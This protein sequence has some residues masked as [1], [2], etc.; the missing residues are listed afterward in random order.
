MHARLVRRH[1]P[2]R[3]PSTRD[4]RENRRRAGPVRHSCSTAECKRALFPMTLEVDPGQRIAR[5]SRSRRN[6]DDDGAVGIA[7]VTRIL[8][9]AIGDDAT[10]LRCRRDDGAAGTHAETVDRASVAGVMHEF[11]VGR[12]EQRMAGAGAVA[13][14]DRSTIADVRCESRSKRVWPRCA[15]RAHAA[16]QTCHARCGRSQARHDCCGSP[17]HRP[18]SRRESDHVDRDIG[19]ATAEAKLAAER[20]DAGAHVLDHLDQAKRADMRLADVRISSGAPALTNSL[21]TLRPW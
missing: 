10:R 20:L 17:R 7:L 21:S 16:S 14:S 5:D 19:H 9:H 11:V 18:R 15:R 12:A 1:A 3:T 2:R 8:A 6:A 13:R 4:R